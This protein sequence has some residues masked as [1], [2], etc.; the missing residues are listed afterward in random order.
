MIASPR[1]NN[2]IYSLH[3][4]L[5]CQ[6]DRAG[7]SLSAYNYDSLYGKKALMMMYRGIMDLVQQFVKF[8]YTIVLYYALVNKHVMLADILQLFRNLYQLFLLD[9]LLKIHLPFKNLSSKQ[10]LPLFQLELSGIQLSVS[11][12]II[13]DN[14]LIV[15]LQQELQKENNPFSYH[16]QEGEEIIKNSPFSFARPLGWSTLILF[17]HSDLLEPIS[18]VKVVL[19]FFFFPDQ[20]LFGCVSQ[21]RPFHP[22]ES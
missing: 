19:I 4:H 12:Y 6:H 5:L 22:L 16:S 17:L 10:K 13:Y 14:Y 15:S 21:P 11:I 18:V 3:V 8:S 20:H 9:V 1:E 7:L 2:Y